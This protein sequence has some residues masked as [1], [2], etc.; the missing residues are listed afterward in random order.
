ML[1]L[2]CNHVKHLVMRRYIS[3]LQNFHSRKISLIFFILGMAIYANSLFNP[4]FG[5]DFHQIKNN[6]SIHS[7]LR[8]PSLFL[9][10]TFNDGSGN[11]INNYYKPLLS[12]TYSLIYFFFGDNPFGY[13]LI[14][15]LVH[16]VNS[17]LIYLLFSKFFEKKISFLLSLLFLTHPINTEAV[18]Y[19]SN[20]QDPLFFLFGMV[21]L[22]FTIKE[23]SLQ[24]VSWATMLL[25][26]SLLA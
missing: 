20:L 19:I 7:V 12:T 14:Q 25:L 24:V 18:V 4:F 1:F 11:Q 26:A 10:G 9:K 8:I 23:K 17:F 22:I 6:P 15:I 5:D 2:I 21:A 13:H 3:Q 16:I